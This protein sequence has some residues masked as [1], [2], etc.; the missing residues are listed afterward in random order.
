MSSSKKRYAVVRPVPS[1]YDNCVRNNVEK[2]D[3]ELARH[4]H[5]EYCRTLQRL[6]LQLIWVERDDS[7]LVKRTILGM[8]LHMRCNSYG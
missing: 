1:S 7:L 2:I 5:R 4:Q 8:S 6:G 3:V